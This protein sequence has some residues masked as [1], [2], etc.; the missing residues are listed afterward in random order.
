MHK[1]YSDTIHV[2]CKKRCFFENPKS[3]I[4]KSKIQKMFEKLVFKLL[5]GVCYLGFGAC[6]WYSG[7]LINVSSV[8]LS[9]KLMRSDCC[10]AVKF[11]G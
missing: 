8:R 2:K 7:L 10:C 5:F 1:Y 11:K 9:K 4:P 6:Y 3:Q